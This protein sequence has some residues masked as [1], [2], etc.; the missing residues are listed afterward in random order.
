MSRSKAYQAKKNHILQLKRQRPELTEREL[1]NL[2]NVS[3]TSVHNMLAASGQN[4]AQKTG[5]DQKSDRDQT[6][7]PVV[8]DQLVTNPDQNSDQIGLEF[9]DSPAPIE[10]KGLVDNAFSSLKSMLGISEKTQAAAPPRIFSA[11]LDPK[12]QRFV[13]ALAPTLA[14]A[15]MSIAAWMWGR[16]GPEYAVLAPDENVAR[17][18]VEPLLRIYARHANFLID[19]D[20]DVADAGASVF[21]LVGYVNV[22]LSLYQQIKQDQQ[23]QEYEHE[24]GQNTINRRRATSHQSKNGTGNAG[25]GYV[26][27]RREDRTNDPG[28]G[29]NGRGS[30]GLDQATLTDKESRQ[31]EALSRLA[32]LDYNHRARRSM[33]AS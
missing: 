27:V 8:T 23:E 29:A 5:H 3:K 7:Q 25:R 10:P 31:R 17:N 1:A 32:E 26:D 19:I 20:P 24:Q 2:V 22:S 21:A 16:I 28:N 30:R 9:E 11:K 15:A 33:R 14:L 12:Q 13:D 4:H 18:I 6:G